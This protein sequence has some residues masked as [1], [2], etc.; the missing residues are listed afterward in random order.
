MVTRWCCWA[1]KCRI[2]RPSQ[3]TAA[4]WLRRWCRIQWNSEG[5]RRVEILSQVLHLHHLG[6][7]NMNNSCFW[8][9]RSQKVRSASGAAQCMF[10]LFTLMNS[11]DVLQEW[12]SH[13]IIGV[14]HAKYSVVEKTIQPVWSTK[15]CLLHSY[16]CISLLL[17]KSCY[18]GLLLNNDMHI[19]LLSV[20]GQVKFFTAVCR[21]INCFALF[22]SL[23]C[24]RLFK[25]LDKVEGFRDFSPKDCLC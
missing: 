4:L 24:L 11:N 9:S 2:A 19:M 7:T 22:L 12:L 13:L 8:R 25:I 15:H 18:G 17:W 20:I 10:C 5:S 6:T 21:E 23:I 3:W 1:P 14:L 16:F